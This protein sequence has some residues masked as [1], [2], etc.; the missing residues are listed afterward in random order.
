M[1]MVVPYGRLTV[2]GP[3]TWVHKAI[4]AYELTLRP[5]PD[6]SNNHAYEYWND[7]QLAAP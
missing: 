4:A 2:V 5:F 1:R 6:L 7:G 3:Q